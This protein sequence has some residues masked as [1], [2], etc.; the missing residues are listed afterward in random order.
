MLSAMVPVAGESTMVKLLDLLTNRYHGGV[1]RMSGSAGVQVE[2][3]ATARLQAGQR[4]RCIMAPRSS[5]V[6]PRGEMRR[7]SVTHVETP[8]RGASQLLE[9]AFM[10]DLTV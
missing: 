7:A 10:D 3:P 9:L 8:A 1:V 4:V 5:G 2:L 6:L